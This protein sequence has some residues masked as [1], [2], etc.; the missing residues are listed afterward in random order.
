MDRRL[1]GSSRGL[2]GRCE[3][4]ILDAA[5]LSASWARERWGNGGGRGEA[6]NP[7]GKGRER[8]RGGAGSQV[9]P[10]KGKQL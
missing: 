3:L 7:P 2:G 1:D 8:K 10:E 6:D 9:G 5:Q 4:A